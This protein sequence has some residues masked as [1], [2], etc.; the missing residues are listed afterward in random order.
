[1]EYGFLFRYVG[2]S[3]D[4]ETFLARSLSLYGKR[5]INLDRNL[6]R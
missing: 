5:D 3:R 6:H 4:W 2:L 1:M